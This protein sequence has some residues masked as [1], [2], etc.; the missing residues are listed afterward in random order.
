LKLLTVVTCT[1]CSTNADSIRLVATTCTTVGGFDTIGGLS[2]KFTKTETTAFGDAMVHNVLGVADYGPVTASGTY[3]PGDTSQKAL[4]GEI[5]HEAASATAARPT[6][7][8]WAAV[9]T[10]N[11]RTHRFKGRVSGGGI[12]SVGVKGKASFDLEIMLDSVPQVCTTA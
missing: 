4:F 1:A 6:A 10:V 5:F 2:G 8:V 9:D 12:N 7:R 3:D 11:K